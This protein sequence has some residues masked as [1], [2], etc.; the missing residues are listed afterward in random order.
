[1]TRARHSGYETNMRHGFRRY[2]SYVRT[3]SSIGFGCGSACT[4]LRIHTTAHIRGAALGRSAGRLAGRVRKVKRR[5]AARRAY[6]STA[7]RGCERDAARKRARRR[8]RGTGG[9]AT[10]GETPRRAATRERRQ[11]GVAGR[12]IAGASERRLYIAAAAVRQCAPDGGT[13]QRRASIGALAVTPTMMLSLSP[14]GASL[15]RSP[16]FGATAAGTLSSPASLSDWCTLRAS[17][18]FS[19][20]RG[21]VRLVS[22]ERQKEKEVRAK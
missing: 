8:E 11:A 17:E 15:S 20:V 22:Q 7:G 5:G 13:R 16:A 19:C 6:V 12:D 9:R 2:P 14:N 10:D 4:L 1:M 3:Y 21:L 18:R